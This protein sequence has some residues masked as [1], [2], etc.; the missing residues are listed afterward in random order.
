MEQ[1]T[2]WEQPAT[3]QTAIWQ[4]VTELK[5]KQNH[6][7]RGLFQRYDDLLE[8]IASLRAEVTALKLNQKESTN[9]LSS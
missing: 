1:L 6:L 8:E 9:A 4:A 2:L 7:R 3:E 5:M